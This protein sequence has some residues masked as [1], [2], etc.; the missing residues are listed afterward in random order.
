MSEE[1][2]ILVDEV[3]GADQPKPITDCINRV[4]MTGQWVATN[5]VGDWDFCLRPAQVI[6]FQE[7]RVHVRFRDGTEAFRSGIQVSIL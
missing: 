2:V 5:Q 4:V 7:N 3:V 6:G 1:K